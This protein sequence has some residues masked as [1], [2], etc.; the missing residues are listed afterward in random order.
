MKEKQLRDLFLT[1]KTNAGKAKEQT[2]IL[3]FLVLI[4]FSSLFSAQSTKGFVITRTAHTSIAEPVIGMIIYCTLDNCV[5]I[6]TAAGWKCFTE[7][8]CPD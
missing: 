2:A 6:Y 5:E 8:G 1:Y 4:C 7:P 3:V